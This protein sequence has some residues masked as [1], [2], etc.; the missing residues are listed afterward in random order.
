MTVDLTRLIRP[1]TWVDLG[2]GYPHKWEDA[3]GVYRIYDFG[4]NWSNDRYSLTSLYGM[5]GRLGQFPD[6]SSAQ[7][8]ANADN[9]AHVLDDIDTEAIAALVEALENCPPTSNPNESAQ[10]HLDRI[11]AWWALTARPALARVKGE[12]L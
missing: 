7:S 11:T 8:A 2:E 12:T 4:S 9:A 6:L 1:L 3:S 5:M 10:W